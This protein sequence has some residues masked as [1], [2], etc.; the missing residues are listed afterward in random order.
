MAS[1]KGALKPKKTKK[2]AKIL[3]PKN[4]GGAMGGVLASQGSKKNGK[5]T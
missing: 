4:G 1:K 3:K 5:K 2:K